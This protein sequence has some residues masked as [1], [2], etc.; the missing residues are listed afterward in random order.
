[1]TGPWPGQIVADL[2]R[3][4]ERVQP[5]ERVEVGAELA[6]GVG[7]HRRAAA[8][9]RVAGQHRAL[10]RQ[11][12]RQRVGGVAGRRDHADLQAVDRDHVAVG[13]ALRTEPVRRVQRAYAAAD[14][15]GELPRRLGVVEVVV[16]EQHDGHLARRRRDR[17]EVGQVGGPGS[18][19]T[20]REE[21]G[22]RSTQVLV[23]S[24]VI[25]LAFGAST[26]V[27]AS[28]ND[29]PAQRHRSRSSTSGV[30]AGPASTAGRRRP[31]HRPPRA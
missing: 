21:S 11:H 17:V 2:V 25:T 8:E 24:S 3:L 7:D 29:P 13:E 14:P 22:S 16:G 20:D 23:P 9:H 26:H 6:V 31:P 18:T 12:E 5:V 27:P 1:M 15:L 30:G 28:P 19:T 4:G 10:G